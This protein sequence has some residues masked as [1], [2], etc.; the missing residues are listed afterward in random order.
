MTDVKNSDFSF[1]DGY[2]Y[3]FGYGYGLDSDIWIKS[4]TLF[5]KFVKIEIINVLF[6]LLIIIIL[7]IYY[8]VNFWI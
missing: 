8:T 4:R 2:G 6:T 5:T 7:A 3:A 1:G